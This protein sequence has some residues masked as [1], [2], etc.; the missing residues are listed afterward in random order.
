MSIKLTVP[1]TTDTLDL[2]PNITVIGVG[3]AGGNAVNNMIESGLEGVEFLVANSDA[4]ALA[5]SSAERCIQM[6]IDVTRGLGA[7]SNPDIGRAAAEES[8]EEILGHIHHSNMLF[9][10]AGLG[11]GTGTGAAPVIARAARDYGILTVGVVTKPFHF[12]GER[13][14]RLA[15]AGLQELQQYVDT[16]LIIPNQNLFY[17]ANEQ[18]TFADAFQMADQVLYSGVRSVTDLMVSPG[19]INLDFADIK[20][21]MS[22]MGKAMMG[23]GEAEGDNRAVEAAE[24]AISNPLLDDSSMQGAQ[25]VLINITAGKDITLF[26][27]DEA[28]NRIRKE[29]DE[30]ANIIFGSTFDEALEGRIRVSVVATGIDAEAQSMSERPVAEIT[31]ARAAAPAIDDAPEPEAEALRTPTP[32]TLFPRPAA[33]APQP[34][35]ADRAE[36]AEKPVYTKPIP[37]I[38]G[39]TAPPAQSAPA[40]HPAPAAS[41]GTA[42]VVVEAPAPAQA[43]AFIPAPPVMGNLAIDETPKAD[44]FTAADM[45]NTRIEPEQIEPQ[46]KSLFER[47]TGVARS[48]RRL[49]KRER[50]AL[51]TA[52]QA[53]PDVAGIES[54]PVI[55]AA[56]A[57]PVKNEMPPTPEPAPE[58]SPEI[59]Q[60]TAPERETPVPDAFEDDIAFTVTDQDALGE[61]EPEE[62]APEATESAPEIAPEPELEDQGAFG[63]LDPDENLSD[64]QESDDLLE[65]PAFLRRQAN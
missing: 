49:P 5:K 46:K 54:D 4:Q 18:T 20:S 64:G 34:K 22:E 15:E 28:A 60:E 48:E 27:V 24:A 25:G 12:E 23:T 17:V 57:E 56:P 44:P 42:S 14:M 50:A 8:L 19:L 1:T 53:Q 32:V 47:V 39:I 51:P 63:G 21:V 52:M 55:E 7:G 31:D 33:L 62:V 65:I 58:I 36:R 9:V 29:V 6:G 26:E 40:A 16:L 59:A 61:T 13:R 2:K 43:E 3:G 11:G 45:V 37:S 30:D 35:I 38:T 41:L 10:T